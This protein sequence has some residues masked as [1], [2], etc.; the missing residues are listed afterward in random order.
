VRQQFLAA[1]GERKPGR[2]EEILYTDEGDP[3]SYQLEYEG[4]GTIL[5]FIHDATQDKFGSQQ[6]TTYT[7]QQ[8]IEDEIGLRLVGC[9]GSEQE[10]MLIPLYTSP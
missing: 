3:I 10:E 9:S 8:L 1:Y 7:C 2:W 6:I 4:N 5:R